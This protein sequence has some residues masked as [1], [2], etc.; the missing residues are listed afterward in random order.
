MK[1]L[2]EKLKKGSALTMA[3]A[4]ILTMS[5][6]ACSTKKAE[7]SDESAETEQVMEEATEEHSEHPSSEEGHENHEHPAAESDTTASEAGAEHPS[8]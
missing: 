4:F 5:L 2:S 3:A 1:F 6:G 8:N 7:E